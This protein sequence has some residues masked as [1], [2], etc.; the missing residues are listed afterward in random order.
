MRSR[1]LETE[2]VN[3]EIFL[4]LGLS[5]S[6]KKAPE[7]PRVLSLVSSILEAT[8]QRNEKKLDSLE[9]KEIVTVFSGLR[10]PTVSIK[11][12][13]ERIFKYTNCSPCCF[14]L[15]YVYIE[16]FLQLPNVHLTSLNV[17]RLLITSVALAAKFI[18]DA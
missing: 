18:D 10:A 1:V 16:R 17:H 11:S 13:I 12:Y 8:V 7:F 6:I 3:S 4:S 2:A 9:I 14:V 5:T 15:G